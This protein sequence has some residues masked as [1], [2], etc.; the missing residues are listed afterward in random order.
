MSGTY[1]PRSSTLFEPSVLNRSLASKLQ[2]AC[3]GSILFKQT[4]KLKTTPAGRLL[5]AHTASGH[6]TSVSDSTGWA[7]PKVST[8]KYSY[9][10][11][12]HSRVVL[13]LEGQT[14]LAT[15]PSPRANNGTGAGTRGDGGENLQP[16]AT[17]GSNGGP[18][19]AN[20]ALSADAGKA[21]GSTAPTENPGQLNPAHSR[22]LMGYP[23]EW[24]S[25]GATAMQSCRKSPRRSSAR[26]S[27]QPISTLS[28]SA[29]LDLIS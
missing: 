14:D 10:R 7:T 16:R 20:G 8:G 19:Q 18:N 24:D 1:G 26:T 5:W 12:D 25:C 3:L 11:G 15:W 9:S 21:I 22:W 6:R 17:D 23:A 4:W 28:N 29:N 2:T 27:T 13:N